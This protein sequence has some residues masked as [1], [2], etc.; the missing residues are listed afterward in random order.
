M[1]AFR[2]VAYC[3]IW[4]L[5]FSAPA[6]AQDGSYT[7][8]DQLS[9]TTFNSLPPFES[10]GAVG[11]LDEETT[12][13]IGYEVGKVWEAGDAP[14][15][16]VKVGD[17]EDSLGAEQMSLRDIA[18]A[19]GFE[20]EDVN[21]SQLR[22]LDELTVDEL[23]SDIGFL[24]DWTVEELV[25][26]I[27]DEKGESPTP[28]GIET[29]FNGEGTIN[30]QIEANPELGEMAA[31]DVFGDLKVT[32]IPNME[33]TQ[34]GKY[35]GISNQTI[36]NVEGL[37]DVAM[38]YF[39]NTKFSL[40]PMATQDV[41]FGPKEYSGIKPTP[42]PVSGGNN[43]TELWGYVACSGGC[44]HI[45]LYQQG[46]EGA[47]WMT[48]EHRVRDGFGVLGSMVSEAGAYRI[49]FGDSF[50]LQVASTD[51]K[52]GAAEW[53]LAFRVCY[54]GFPDLGCT[55]Y[56]MEVPLGITTY[57]GD[58][59]LT[60]F[61]DMRGGSLAPMDAPPGWENLR[62]ETPREISNVIGQNTADYGGSFRS[63]CGD[64][65]GGV[66]MEA[67]S[68]AF[69]KIES[70]GSG[71]YGAIG[72]WVNLSAGETG[73]AL[74]RYQYMSYREDA[75]AK[76]ST[77]AAGRSLLQRAR[78]RGANITRAEVLEAFPP[79]MQEEVFQEDQA[80]NIEAALAAGYEGE[81]ML[82][83]VAQMHFRGSGILTNGQLNSDYV[84]D[85]NQTTT[86]EYGRRFVEYYK[87]AEAKLPEGDEDER[88]KSTGTYINP[89]R[90]G[91]KGIRRGFNPVPTRH[92][93]RGT[94]SK[95]DG[96]DIPMPQGSDIV[97]SDG[98]VVEWRDNPRGYGWYMVVSHDDGNQT[99]YAHLSKRIAPNGA[100][101]KQGQTI[102]LSGG[103]PGV[104]GSGGSTGPHLH[105]EFREG[106]RTP[107]SPPKWVDYSKTVADIGG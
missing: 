46:W 3:L 25:E 1:W 20:L 42:D 49:P 13:T 28:Y 4:L 21:V 17:I 7:F 95:H 6:N 100:K 9:S 43:G 52:T 98:G 83:V 85:G 41:V 55:A 97:A 56:F 47:Q 104:Q 54:R 62:P 24:G 73:R 39:P 14:A 93:I 86:R 23:L 102:A 66:K 29:V 91:Y 48:K 81:E 33:Y 94:L 92:P 36:S 11:S 51:E 82:S 34:L 87:E 101:V 45:E 69:H 40:F 30:E 106:G 79:D 77:T 64:G 22:F 103:A 53:G 75:V 38:A 10:G 8:A 84:K 96:D 90:E 18:D 37:G 70:R 32:D 105:F 59:V 61:R 19:A 89:S 99:W 27:E 58:T 67:L 88:C 16:V 72:I 63:L 60:G 107:V 57:E 31:Q 26:K 74:G 80:R 78:I 68:E 44:P 15:D 71:D 12:A 50:A 5:L 2:L 65:P 35:E 76:I